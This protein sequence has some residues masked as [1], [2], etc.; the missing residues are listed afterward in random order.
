MIRVGYTS[1]FGSL[2]YVSAGGTVLVSRTGHSYRQFGEL[3]DGLE[4][5]VNADQVV[6]DARSSASIDRLLALIV[7]KFSL[8]VAAS[9]DLGAGRFTIKV[10]VG[11]TG[12]YRCC[13]PTS[14]GRTQGRSAA[15]GIGRGPRRIP[16]R[17]GRWARGRTG[18]ATLA[19]E[20]DRAAQKLTLSP[21]GN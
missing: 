21:F 4:L 8:D 16:A 7:G 19:E 1:C 5:D 2:A 9:S 12:Y 14:A 11:V 15:G 10:T 18:T 13:S 3:R 6:L 17:E 20:S